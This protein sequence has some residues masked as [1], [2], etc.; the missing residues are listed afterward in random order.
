[1]DLDLQTSQGKARQ[2][3]AAPRVKTKIWGLICISAHEHSQQ[4]TQIAAN[5][6]RARFPLRRQNKTTNFLCPEIQTASYDNFLI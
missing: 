4:A 3:K 2:G 5:V 6:F 1:M